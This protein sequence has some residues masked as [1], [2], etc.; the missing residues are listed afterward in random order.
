MI[1]TQQ[2]ILLQS[3]H[4]FAAC[5][6]LAFVEIQIEGEHGWAKNLPTWRGQPEWAAPGSLF[7]AMVRNTFRWF[8]GGNEITGYHLS[9]M[10]F[11]FVILLL[12][13]RLILFTK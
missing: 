4:I 8:S 2:D 6:A 1:F 11:L 5:I 10:S 12:P 3:L 7:F 9:L 13:V